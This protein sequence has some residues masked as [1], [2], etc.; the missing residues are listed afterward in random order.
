MTTV[1]IYKKAGIILRIEV[2]GHSGYAAEG[3]DIVCAAVTS[4]VRYA[5]V[6]L[7]EVLNLGILFVTDPETAFIS[8]DYPV[9]S[10]AIEKL[11]SC[12]ATFVGFARYM[13]GLSAEYPD[14]IKVM[15]VQHNA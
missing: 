1:N 3:E 9:N 7:N 11:S 6:I 15:E 13:K 14:Y 12:S 8:F 5:E 2:S 10:P 4:A